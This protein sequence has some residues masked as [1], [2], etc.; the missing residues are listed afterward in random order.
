[1][2]KNTVRVPV[3][4]PPLMVT[5]SQYT[6]R[7]FSASRLKHAKKFCPNWNSFDSSFTKSFVSPAKR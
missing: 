4:K 7:S 6:M 1:M 5:R 2:E 3:S